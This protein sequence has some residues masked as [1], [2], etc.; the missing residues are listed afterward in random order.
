MSYWVT[1]YCRDCAEY[2]PEDCVQLGDEMIGPFDNFK[3]AEAYAEEVDDSPITST[4]I[5]RDVS[6]VSYPSKPDEKI[7]LM[8]V[9]EATK[10]ALEFDE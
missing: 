5:E 9:E 6:K 4:V 7:L 3:T 8:I 10:K 2:Y 1:F